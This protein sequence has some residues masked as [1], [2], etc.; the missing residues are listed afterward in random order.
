METS[1]KLKSLSNFGLVKY[2]IEF[3]GRHFI[4]V[5]GAGLI[6]AVGRA[7]QLGARGEISG[8]LNL[9]LEIVI[10]VAR[11]S[12][13][14]LVIGEGNVGKGVQRVKTIFYL[15]SDQWKLIGITVIARLK[16]NWLALILNLLTYSA[17]A[18]IIN[19]VIDKIAYNTNLLKTLQNSNI[20]ATGTTEWVL[21]LFFKNITVIP[22]TIIF[23]G[24]ILLWLTNSLM[25]REK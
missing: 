19:F 14:L 2:S 7:I 22:F 6:A 8:G 11:I 16:L 15:K 4:F 5:F 13:F 17:I 20:L 23:N 1:A 12:T 24:F 25:S 18:M 3:F 21:L 9:L 10:A